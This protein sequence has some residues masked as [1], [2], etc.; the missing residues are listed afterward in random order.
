MSRVNRWRTP[1]VILLATFVLL[2]ATS[3]V[4]IVS[5]PGPED[6]QGGREL[7]LAPG[8]IGL[9]RAV[10]LSRC[11]S[12]FDPRYSRDCDLRYAPL[13]AMHGLCPDHSLPPPGGR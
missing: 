4:V 1:D 9:G 10:D 7:A 8:G 12:A 3:M 11:G 5:A 6:A 13:P 2:V